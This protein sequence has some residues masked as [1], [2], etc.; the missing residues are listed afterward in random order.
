MKFTVPSVWFTLDQ[1][2]CLGKVVSVDA[3]SPRPLTVR[4]HEARG[5]NRDFVFDSFMPAVDPE[6]EGDPL[7]KQIAVHEVIMRFP[8][9]TVRGFMSAAVRR[10]LL[11]AL[12]R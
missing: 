8:E 7:V 2:P 3:S 10:R 11:K 6:S 4:L 1:L 9:L 12:S 5:R